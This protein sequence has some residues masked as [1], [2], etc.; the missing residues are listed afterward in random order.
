M[1]VIADGLATSVKLG[2]IAAFLAL[3]VGVVLGSIAALKR[4]KLID[5]II[6]VVTTAFVSMPSFIMGTL[7]LLVF[8]SM[9][10][11]FPANG[12]AD[13]GF[14]AGRDGARVLAGI[15]A[16]IGSGTRDAG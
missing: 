15:R 12:S 14:A 1:G 3:A 13:A 11:W 6:M 5:R 7:L 4:N 2:V 8:S 10:G 9:L 16:R